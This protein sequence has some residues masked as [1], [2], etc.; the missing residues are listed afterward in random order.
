MKY[1]KIT[2]EKENH[3]GL[4]YKT[5]LNEDPVPWNPNGNCQAGGIYFASKD[6]LVFLSYGIWIREVVIPQGVPV[7]RDFGRSEKF[8]APKV[9]LKRRRKI[10]AEV[11]Q[12]LIEAGADPKACD[13]YALRW[14][15]KNGHLE[16]VKLLEAQE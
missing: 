9:L 10:T 2:N 16:I 12:E 13:S 4:Q 14:A 15:A 7:Y 6:I 8:K 3:H 11:I 1:Y 5:G